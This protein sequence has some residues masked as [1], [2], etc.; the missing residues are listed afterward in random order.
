M[1]WRW[2]YISCS[3]VIVNLGSFRKGSRIYRAHFKRGWIQKEFIFLPCFSCEIADGFTFGI[4]RCSLNH[5]IIGL[6]GMDF[7]NK[8]VCAVSMLVIGK[9]VQPVLSSSNP[10]GVMQKRPRVCC[11][12]EVKPSIRSTW[13]DEVGNLILQSEKVAFKQFE[14]QHQH[15]MWGTRCPEKP[16]GRISSLAGGTK[17]YLD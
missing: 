9:L 5:V 14:T 13:V 17:G 11:T 16:N 2:Q 12:C 15:K 7:H 3:W 8:R 10:C 6:V 4:S 1:T